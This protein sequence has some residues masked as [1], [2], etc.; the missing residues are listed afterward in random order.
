[1]SHR[2]H[3]VIIAG[4]EL[5]LAV[6]PYSLVQYLVRELICSIEHRVAPTMSVLPAFSHSTMLRH[7]CPADDRGAVYTLSVTLIAWR[8]CN[9][10]A[11][12]S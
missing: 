4:V 11:S 5:A 1:M 3:G 10:Q 8:S 9:R 6:I 2:I 7:T 12:R